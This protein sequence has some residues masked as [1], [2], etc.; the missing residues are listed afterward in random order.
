MIWATASSFAQYRQ[1]E[2]SESVADSIPLLVGAQK[3]ISDLQLKKLEKHFLR[4]KPGRCAFSFDDVTDT[5][6]GNCVW[7]RAYGSPTGCLPEGISHSLV[8]QPRLNSGKAKIARKRTTS[9]DSLSSCSGRTRKKAKAPDT[10]KRVDKATTSTPSELEAQSESPKWENESPVKESDVEPKEVATV[11]C[12]VQQVDKEPE[13]A[14][15]SK[16]SHGH[17][18]ESQKVLSRFESLPGELLNDI[19]TLVLSYPDPLVI[20]T[21]EKSPDVPRLQESSN[22]SHR[23]ALFRVNRLMRARY[24]SY[25]FDKN[26]FQIQGYRNPAPFFRR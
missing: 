8:T 11:E 13:T 18:E 9:K 4:C 20:T 10:S 26:Q 2:N 12:P 23:T 3:Y 21:T 25:L 1:S 24:T 14:E 5:V 15:T 17:M 19:A 16:T 22:E 6:T 7:D